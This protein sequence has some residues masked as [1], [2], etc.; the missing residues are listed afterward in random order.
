MS[1]IQETDNRYWSNVL[2]ADMTG[3]SSH[4][5]VA[6]DWGRELLSARDDGE[7]ASLKNIW[8]KTAASRRMPGFSA[9]I[10]PAPADGFIPSA[11]YTWGLLYNRRLLAVLGSD[12]I[13]DMDSFIPT[14]EKAKAKG[15]IP[16]SL[17]ATNGWAGAA[18][19]AYLDL[20]MNGG[21]AA[22][23]R[24]MGARPFNDAGGRD[25]ANVLAAWRDAGFFAPDARASGPWNMSALLKG[26]AL[27]ML[28]GAFAA[29]SLAW[30]EIGFMEVP[31]W[32]SKGEPRGEIVG[33][34][35][36]AVPAS[37]AAPEGAVALADAYL[38]DGRLGDALG[39]YWLPI[40]F[41]Q[42]DGEDLPSIQ[43]RVLSKTRWVFPSQDRIMP[44]QFVQSSLRAWASFFKPGSG[45]SGSD[46]AELLQ[47]SIPAAN[48][49]ADSEAKAVRR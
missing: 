33:L 24:I 8:P 9:S 17:G 11:I 4:D 38:S 7:L 42:K 15:I 36:F 29:E 28:T 31:F 6:A 19:L 45:M 3:G 35:G 30:S 1:L 47:A 22:W 2:K 10:L 34:L 23:E 44:P 41:E 48:A 46:L 40:E 16:I 37:A 21:K 13:E 14:L 32:K 27:F 49:P 18:W 43:S 20:R 26:D 39:G 25:A 5:L 12:R